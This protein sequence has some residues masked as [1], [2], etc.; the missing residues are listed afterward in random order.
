MIDIKHLTHIIKQGYGADLQYEDY[1]ITSRYYDGSVFQVVKQNKV[2]SR[3]REM[4]ELVENPYS[5]FVRQC[6]KLDMTKKTHKDDEDGWEEKRIKVYKL[7][8]TSWNDAT[9]KFPVISSPIIF[10]EKIIDFKKIYKWEYEAVKSIANSP[11]TSQRQKDENATLLPFL[12]ELFNIEPFSAFYD[13]K[14]GFLLK[15]KINFV[16]IV[17][18]EESGSAMGTIMTEVKKNEEMI[19]G[20]YKSQPEFKRDVITE[21]IHPKRVDYLIEKHGIEEGMATFD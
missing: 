16:R 8:L 7:S 18:V 1:A 15:R 4:A 5:E 12:E 13:D 9:N 10:R 3:G 21:A 20:S 19:K 6:D 17:E 11:K 2:N 14:Y